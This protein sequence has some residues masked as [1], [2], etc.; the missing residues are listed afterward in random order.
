L[1][2]QTGF[3]V[4]TFFEMKAAQVAGPRVQEGFDSNQ[5]DGTANLNGIF[6]SRSESL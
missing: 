1:H 6:P 4:G 5:V 3:E 2:E